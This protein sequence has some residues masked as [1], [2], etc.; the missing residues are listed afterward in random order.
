MTIKQLE[1]KEEQL[2][3]SLASLEGQCELL[4]TQIDS[5]KQQLEELAH[6]KEVYSKTVE[7]FV[8]LQEATQQ[9]VKEGF[10]KIVSYALQY[11][12]GEE[13]KFELYFEK[14]GNLQE[15]N[16][17]FISPAG[18]EITDPMEAL[19]GGILDVASIALRIALLELHKPKSDSFIAFDEPTRNVSAQFISKCGEFFKH[20]NRQIHR[21]IIL[22]THQEAL[23]EKS[24][25]QI[26]LNKEE[27]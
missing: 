16:F 21:Q 8:L 24:D 27:K 10:E 17:K 20:I 25:V 13:Y 22:V 3:N 6:K 26:K 4:D 15:C 1:Q 5:N 2:K 12:F 7:V 18:I 14:R 11:I 23:M 9:Q 19:G